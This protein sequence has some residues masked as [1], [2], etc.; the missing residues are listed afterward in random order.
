[1]QVITS[2]FLEELVWIWG[3][4]L[5]TLMTEDFTSCLKRLGCTIPVYPSQKSSK[6]KRIQYLS[7]QLCLSKNNSFPAS[8]KGRCVGC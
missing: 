4:L 3:A 2:Y 5:E 7:S 8:S 1:M 6:K